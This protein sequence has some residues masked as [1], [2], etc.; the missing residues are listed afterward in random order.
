MK[1]PSQYL[2]VCRFNFFHGH[3]MYCRLLFLLFLIY[4]SYKM[5]NDTQSSWFE[6]D[7]VSFYSNVTATITRHYDPHLSCDITSEDVVLTHW[8]DPDV[9]LTFDSYPQ[10][11]RHLL[12]Q[13]FSQVQCNMYVSICQCILSYISMD[14]LYVYR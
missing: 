4:N 11:S 7:P 13:G 8:G 2:S 14:N 10:L 12:E 9:V 3:S 6:S 5:K 1:A